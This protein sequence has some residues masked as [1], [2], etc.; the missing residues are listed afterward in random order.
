MAE[1]SLSPETEVKFTSKS[2]EDRSS[3]EMK[4]ESGEYVSKFRLDKHANKFKSY[5]YETIYIVYDGETVVD[6]W[7]QCSKCGWLKCINI[8]SD[9]TNPFRRH[10][11]DKKGEC[12]KKSLEKETGLVTSQPL[13]C[14]SRD[15][16]AK[17]FSNVC[18]IGAVLGKVTQAQFSE[19]MPEKFG[20]TEKM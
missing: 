10:V 7:F 1:A 8:S 12:K 15:D 19:I 9:G 14:L 11:E 4:L 18:S 17:A 13:L 2:I 5:V 20:D 16:L 6:D 3:V